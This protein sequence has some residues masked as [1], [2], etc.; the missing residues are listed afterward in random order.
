MDIKIDKVGTESKQ[1]NPWATADVKAAFQQYWDSPSYNWD[2]KIDR[3]MKLAIEDGK[4]AYGE[5]GLLEAPTTGLEEFLEGEIHPIL[6]KD[7]F[8]T[9]IPDSVF[10]STYESMRPALRLVTEILSN[11]FIL[12]WFVHVLYGDRNKIDSCTAVLEKSSEQ[13]HNLPEI[14]VRAWEELLELSK[15]IKFTF[16]GRSR[17]G[18]AAAC[19]HATFDTL[20]EYLNIPD[21]KRNSKK[22]R[23]EIRI[24]IVMHLNLFLAQLCLARHTYPTL[25]TSQKLRG[26]IGFAACILHELGHAW[27]YHCYG[28]LLDEPRASKSER[29]A[30]LG[31]SLQELVFGAF[32]GATKFDWTTGETRIR[33]LIVRRFEDQF[34]YRVNMEEMA[35]MKWIQ[36]WFDASTWASGTNPQA[37]IRL[38]APVPLSQNLP[39]FFSVL[40]F[41]NG[42][43]E[44]DIHPQYQEGS[45]CTVCEQWCVCHEFRQSGAQ[46]VREWYRSVWAIEAKKALDADRLPEEFY[47]PSGKYAHLFPDFVPPSWA[48]GE[49]SK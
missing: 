28:S 32:F 40:R 45:A 19:T 2:A 12:E 41:R 31:F 49:T 1:A 13:Q 46:S 7:N 44:N 22:P 33:P 4:K 37:E 39:P 23:N 16:A 26:Q 21:F 42:R 8:I 3:G 9:D 48:L 18:N 17:M 38:K 36:A 25:T 35:S 27:H 6:S 5:L 47:K 43:L 20:F 24:T 14:K 11:D 29:F 30:E 15:N 10:L 34:P